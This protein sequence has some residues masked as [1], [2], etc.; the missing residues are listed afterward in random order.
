MEVDPLDEVSTDILPG[1][2]TLGTEQ[3]SSL[4]LR[5]MHRCVLQP[6]C[7]HGLPGYGV[8]RSLLARAWWI[9][10]ETHGARRLSLLAPVGPK[11][12]GGLPVKRW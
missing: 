6:L 8:V 4:C 12:S 7:I 2:M 10:L 11:G 9:A 1:S 3:R 5:V